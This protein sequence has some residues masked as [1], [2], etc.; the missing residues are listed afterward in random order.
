MN[1]RQLYICCFPFL[2]DDEEL[3]LFSRKIP[4]IFGNSLA[5]CLSPLDY[6]FFSPLDRCEGEVRILGNL[7]ESTAHRGQVC[8][9]SLSQEDL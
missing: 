4:H 8:S 7:G 2:Y 9:R 1:R 3:P 5:N 6:Y